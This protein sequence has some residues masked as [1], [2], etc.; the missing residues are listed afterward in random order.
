ME[1]GRPE[2]REWVD[3]EADPPW[4]LMPLTHIA[5]A[6]LAKDIIRSGKVDTSDCQVFNRSL[7][8]FFYGRPAY[9]VSG[10]GAIKTAAT[11]P[12]CFIFDPMIAENADSIHAFDTGAFE[13]RLYT[14]TLL[15]EMNIADFSLGKDLSRANRLISKVFI[16]RD[17]YYDGSMCEIAESD[18]LAPPGEFLARA[19]IDLLKSVGRNEPDD[20]VG[21]I[22]VT[23]GEPVSIEGTLLAI[24]V[25]DI[26]WGDKHQTNWLLT[27]LNSGVEILP[28]RFLMGKDS[29][30][31]HAMIELQIR[32]FYRLNRYI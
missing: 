10:E 29:S 5:K 6:F 20:R 19:Y 13:R 24:A 32:E 2:F 3:R 11:C 26:L 14:H 31:H 23:F 21:T 8:Y 12:F 1:H 27:L 25:P 15:D 16:R 4:G 18:I 22:E 9:R 17:I 7:A 30:Y 28:Y